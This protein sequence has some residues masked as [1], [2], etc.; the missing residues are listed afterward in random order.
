MSKNLFFL[1]ILVAA[2]FVLFKNKKVAPNEEDYQVVRQFHPVVEQPIALK[3]SAI[4]KEIPTSVKMNLADADELHRL[5]E[6]MLKLKEISFPN[7]KL[8]A[9]KPLDKSSHY[10]EYETKEGDKVSNIYHENILTSSS[11][12]SPSGKK[13]TRSYE[14]GRLLALT[15]EFGNDS[16]TLFLDSNALVAKRIELHSHK[17]TCYKYDGSGHPYEKHT[18]DCRNDDFREYEDL[19]DR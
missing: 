4:R 17:Q 15:E 3:S 14:E 2:S 13:F 5:D 1:A 10:E 19:T 9:K 12:E 7:G 18:G 6:V 16:V 11:W 8:V